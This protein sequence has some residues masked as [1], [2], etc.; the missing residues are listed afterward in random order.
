MANFI[1]VDLCGGKGKIVVN[2]AHITAIVPRF[3]DVGETFW[4]INRAEGEWV[5]S[6]L[7]PACGARFKVDVVADEIIQAIEQASA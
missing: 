2:P 7:Y 4:T 5:F 1:H 3:N 6:D